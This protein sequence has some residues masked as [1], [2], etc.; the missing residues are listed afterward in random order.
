[1]RVG[2]V[3]LAAVAVLLVNTVSVCADTLTDVVAE[4]LS[5]N[6]ELGAIRFNRR[7]ID[8]ELNAARGLN[9]PTLDVEARVGRE[10][11]SYVAGS[12]IEDTNE[13]HQGKGVSTILSQR[14]FDG[15]E[16][17]HE[18]AR[19]KN[20][21]DS[22]RWR[23]ND[24][25]NS[26]ALRAVQAYLEVIRAGQVL[27]AART[28]LTAHQ[29]LNARVSARFDAGKANAAEGAEAGARTANA[30]AIV[31][32]AEARLQDAYALFKSVVGRLPGKLAPAPAAKGLP[33]SVEA[34]VGEAVIAAPS[35]MATQFDTLAAQASIGQAYSRFFPKLNLEVS[36]DHGRGVTEDHDR[37][38][39]ARALLV[40]RYNLFNGGIDKARLWEAK[41]RAAEAAEISAN[42]ERIIERETRVSWNALVSAS[43]RVGDLRRQLD[44]QR[45]RRAAYLEQFDTGSRR[46]LDL[47]DAQAEIFLAESTLRTEELIGVYSGYRL[48]AAMG[49]LVPALGLDQPPEAVEP[50]AANLIEGW[51]TEIIYWPRE[52]F[53]IGNRDSG[54]SGAK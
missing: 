8:N 13:W 3:A 32:E 52:N 31:A 36:T 4:A 28:N 41:A 24:T 25:A 34:A 19:Q 1:M 48:L 27:A 10:R 5:T 21:V 44:L 50:H 49:R 29:G 23:V 18:I 2:K 39:D 35:I 45:Q 46:L 22:A 40:V 54:G 16:A 51:R 53:H 11:N 12:G 43:Q 26:I 20:R 42:T 38:L 30:K 37:D 33:G 6:P 14:I 17:R 47:L 9:L 7:A 15:F